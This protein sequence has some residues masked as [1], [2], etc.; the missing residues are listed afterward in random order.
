MWRLVFLGF[1]DINETA[2]D[3]CDDDDNGIAIPP[4]YQHRCRLRRLI[5][6]VDDFLQIDIDLVNEFI[7]SVVYNLL[8]VL[9]LNL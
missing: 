6:K 1:R 2:N 3:E 8:V 4:S 7:I 5:N 9:F